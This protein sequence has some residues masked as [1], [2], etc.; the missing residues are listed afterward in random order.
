MCTSCLPG[1]SRIQ[2]VKS[3]ELELPMVVSHHVC[4]CWESNLG[5]C[6]KSKHFQPLSHLSSSKNTLSTFNISFS[7][8]S[9]WNLGAS[10][11]YV[12][13]NCFIFA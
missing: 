2:S 1:A 9:C 4:G 3:L 7:L 13:E 5:L 8:V 10:F 11:P 12:V 6:K